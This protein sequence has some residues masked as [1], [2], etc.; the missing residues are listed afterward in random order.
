MN[1]VSKDHTVKFQED[2]EISL[3]PE[4][5][6]E[7]PPSYRKLPRKIRQQILNAI[8]SIS[9]Y[10]DDMSPCPCDNTSHS[11]KPWEETEGW[12][13]KEYIEYD[14]MMRRKLATEQEAF[15]GED[16]AYYRMR[17]VEKI[18]QRMK[19]GLEDE[20]LEIKLARPRSLKKIQRMM[21]AKTG[22]LEVRRFEA[23]A[24]RLDGALSLERG[25]LGKKLR[26]EVADVLEIRKREVDEIVEE[27]CKGNGWLILG[28]EWYE[29]A[30]TSGY[31]ERV[32]D[33]SSFEDGR[34]FTEDS[35]DLETPK[36]VGAGQIYKVSTWL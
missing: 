13:E 28:D 36:V 22:A 35:W 18:S 34:W 29:W 30:E 31:A 14:K 27:C 5:I 21:A 24:K 11:F 20:I 3:A 17:R 4:G 16:Q 12:R 25:E 15:G 2:D 6:T 7:E 9:I 10:H 1:N 33:E 8:F 26:E 23:L 19:A 32:H